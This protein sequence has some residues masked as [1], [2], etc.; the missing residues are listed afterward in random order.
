[1]LLQMLCLIGEAFDDFSDDVCG[2]VMNIR[3]KGDKI[4]LWTADGNRTS[5][6]VEIG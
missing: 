4:G 1:M 3:Q 6:I 5:S 2:A